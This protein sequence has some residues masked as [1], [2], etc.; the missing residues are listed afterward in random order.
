VESEPPVQRDV[1]E[2]DRKLNCQARRTRAV[3]DASKIL[4][5]GKVLLAPSQWVQAIHPTQHKI[6]APPAGLYLARGGPEGLCRYIQT[7]LPPAS[8]S[9]PRGTRLSVTSHLAFGQQGIRPGPDS[10]GHGLR[11]SPHALAGPAPP[12]ARMDKVL[13]NNY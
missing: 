10:W 7:A 3:D 8:V 9:S 1:R 11:T 12:R 13:R 2:Y 5:E 4:P 6:M